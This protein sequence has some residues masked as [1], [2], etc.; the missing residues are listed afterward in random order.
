M[1]GW[2][3]TTWA[4]FFWMVVLAMFILVTANPVDP[5]N[6]DGVAFVFAPIWC[7]VMIGL[8]VIWVMTRARRSKRAR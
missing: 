3:V 2:R 4:I 6:G 5:T 8:L 7:F 1:P